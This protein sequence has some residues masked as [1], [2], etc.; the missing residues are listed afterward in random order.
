[1][2]ILTMVL[3]VKSKFFSGIK[4]LESQSF[5]TKLEEFHQ[6]ACAETPEYTR[7]PKR[8][9]CLIED[10]INSIKTLLGNIWNTPE[11]FGILSRASSP[12]IIV[13]IEVDNDYTAYSVN[14]IY[15][16][17]PNLLAPSE[18]YETS[19]F[20]KAIQSE[21]DGVFKNYGFIAIPPKKYRVR[22]DHHEAV[23]DEHQLS[24][25]RREHPG[26]YF[27]VADAI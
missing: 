2:K 22:F 20:E 10:S 13:D 21:K 15:S 16:K 17:F 26:F 23:L 14:V 11:K 19:N 4:P 7:N 9:R 27:D 5:D 12:E 8:A 3:P 6:K 24:E 25:L 18:T 1:M